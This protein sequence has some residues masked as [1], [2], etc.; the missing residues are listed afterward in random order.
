MEKIEYIECDC[1][2]ELLQLSFEQDNSM[3]TP[4]GEDLRFLNIAYYRHGH[5]GRRASLRERLRHIW[6]ILKNGHPWT[7]E[8]ILR[9]PER[10]KLTKYLNNIYMPDA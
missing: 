8:I 10:L 6:Y 2:C 9:E 1:G 4:A 5:S 3:I 7:D